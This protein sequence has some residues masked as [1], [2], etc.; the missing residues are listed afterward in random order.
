M[1]KNKKAKSQRSPHPLVHDRVET[2]RHLVPRRQRRDGTVEQPTPPKMVVPLGAETPAE[3]LVAEPEVQ[4]EPSREAEAE[5]TPADPVPEAA[6]EVQAEAAPEGPTTDVVPGQVNE[7]AA[8]EA[9]AKQVPEASP[10]EAAEAPAEQTPET[11]VEPATD[12]QAPATA[13]AAK[14]PA[15]KPKS[16]KADGPKKMTAINAAAQVVAEAGKPM[17]C[18]EMIEEMSKR[19]LWTSPG[20]ATPAATLYSAILNELKKGAASRFQKVDRGKFAAKAP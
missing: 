18:A 10:E 15:R 20:G 16:K 5:A 12:A 19:K 3:L 11:P 13:D 9:Q 1:S 6:A 4:P 17:T 8:P 7:V 2:R 14:K